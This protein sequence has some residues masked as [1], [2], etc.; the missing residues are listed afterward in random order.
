MSDLFKE[1]SVSM[2]KKFPDVSNLVSEELSLISSASRNNIS[3]PSSQS[4]NFELCQNLELLRR[5]VESLVSKRDLIIKYLHTM[6]KQQRYLPASLPSHKKVTEAVSSLDSLLSS[7]SLDIHV[8][9]TEQ[10]KQSLLSTEND[11]KN[12]ANFNRDMV[13]AIRQLNKAHNLL[14]NSP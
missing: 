4:Q 13:L 3:K 6:D 9:S 11:I 1:C 10:L 5:N 14:E 8:F 2:K 12:L 7:E